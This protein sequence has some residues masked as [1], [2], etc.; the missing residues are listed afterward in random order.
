MFR[1]QISADAEPHRRLIGAVHGPRLRQ[2][3]AWPANDKCRLND[4]EPSFEPL[5]A[6]S[7]ILRSRKAATVDAK[8]RQLAGQLVFVPVLLF[9]TGRDHRSRLQ[10]RANQQKAAKGTKDVATRATN[11][12]LFVTFC[13]GL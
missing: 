11:F 9:A 8:K 12:V 7:K 10:P 2:A 5:S 3:P 1:E 4:E 13:S 6:H